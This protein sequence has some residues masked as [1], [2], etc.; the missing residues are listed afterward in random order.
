[1]NISKLSEWLTIST[2]I[3]V[4]AGI[5]ALAYEIS[6]N[7]KQL[8]AQASYNM[9][10]NRSEARNDIVNNVELAEFWAKVENGEHPTEV[11]MIRIRA[12][13]EITILKWQWEY[14]Q[15]M[16]GNLSID[17]LPVRAYRTAYRGDYSAQ[18][19]G[20]PDAWLKLR[21]DLRP[22]FAEWMEINVIKQ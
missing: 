18:L 10:L 2:N 19:S 17:E 1:V 3:A 20:L 21:D 4:L 13:A 5:F 11:D 16:D 7:T 15:Y 14:G 22:D 9:L 12:S 8:R 6:Q